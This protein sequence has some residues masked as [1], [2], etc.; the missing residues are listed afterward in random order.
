M[1]SPVEG[2]RHDAFMIGVSSLDGKLRRFQRPNGE[3]NVIYGDS[4]YGLSRNILAPYRGVR[5]TDNQQESNSQMSK[6][7]CSVEWGFGKISQLFAFLDCVVP[8]N[9]H[10]PPQR[11]FFQFEP[12][13]PRIF[14][15]RGLHLTSPYPLEFP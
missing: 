10:T 7:R 3:P 6:M 9:I 5:L 15:S 4:A 8:E 11:V 12:P 13:P 1:F 2:N 14:R